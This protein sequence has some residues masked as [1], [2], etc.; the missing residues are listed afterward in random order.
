[1]SEPGAMSSWRRILA[2]YFSGQFARFLL[3]GGISAVLNWV[4]RVAFNSFMGFTAAVF[5]AYAIG[6]AVAYTLNRRFVFPNSERSMDV[7]IRYFVLF[8]IVSLPIVWAVASLLGE[9]V[10]TRW[11]APSM[12]RGVGHAVALCV[13]VLTNFVLHKFITFKGAKL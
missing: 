5:C 3:A 1:M 8:N 4:S 12:A 2:L 13:P 7:E 11:F 6:M 9:H 10:L